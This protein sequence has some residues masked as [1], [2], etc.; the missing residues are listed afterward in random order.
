[1][2]RVTQPTWP[3]PD[4]GDCTY[5]GHRVLD[6]GVTIIIYT[7][8]PRAPACPGCDQCEVAAIPGDPSSA[9]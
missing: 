9:R 5:I 8:C 3:M 1:M 4:L 7:T 6:D 2:G